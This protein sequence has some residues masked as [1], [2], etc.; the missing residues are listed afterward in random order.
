MLLVEP[1]DGTASP[2][3][4]AFNLA[5]W[6]VKR[7]HE[8][9]CAF[10]RARKL[11]PDAVV[12]RDGVNG[13]GATLLRK[14]R[15][16]A[17]TALLP[18]LAL[19]APDSSDRPEFATF[20]AQACL[21]QSASDADVVE[22]VRGILGKRPKVTQ[23]PPSVLG[24]PARMAVLARTGLMDTPPEELFDRVT[25]LTAHLLDVPAVLMSLV[26]QQRQFFK[27]NV[28]L[29]G[30][31]AA[32][33]QTPIS[34]SFCQWVVAADDDLIVPDTSRHPLLGEN[35]AAK[36]MSV[37]AYAGVPLHAGSAETIG[38]FCAI[39]I[40]PHQWTDVELASLRDTAMLIDA[41]AALR[42]GSC[43]P[44]TSSALRTAAH[45]TGLAVDAASRLLEVNAKMLTGDERLQL[46]ALSGE[47]GRQL[48]DLSAQ[49]PA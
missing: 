48:A 24:A 16:N 15:S 19:V 13:G 27:S 29:T 42:Q 7:E 44:V 46:I 47:L 18:V 3:A 22:G 35:P 49:A 12:V 14:L 39:D 10:D 11:N 4:R 33:R 9:G 20:G 37:A 5:G 17:H 6:D 23:A 25:R 2:L 31:L 41:I 21:D 1:D 34:H 32:T 28:G 26:D 40:K 30:D 43:P 36:L 45:A 8:C 38:S